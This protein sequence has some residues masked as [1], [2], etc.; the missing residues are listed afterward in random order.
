MRNDYDD[1]DLCEDRGR[2]KQKGGCLGCLGCLIP[3]LILIS[4]LVLLVFGAVGFIWSRAVSP[5]FN[6]ETIAVN[7]D[8]SPS[9]EEESER[10]RSIFLFGVDSRD[11]D[12]L[13]SGALADADLLLTIDQETGEI[14]LTSFYRDT[15]VETTDGSRMKLTEVYSKYGPKEAIQTINK[16]CDLNV[17]EFVTVTWSAVAGLIN[18]LGGIDI[19]ITEAE[20][21]G[22]NTYLNETAENTGISSSPVNEDISETGEIVHLDG[23]QAVSYSRLRK[24]LGDD[25]QRTVRQRTVIAAVFA[26]AK[27]DPKLTAATAYTILPMIATNINILDLFEMAAAIPLYHMGENYGFPH[28]KTDDASYV[29]P[30]TLADNDIWLHTTVY[31][32]SSY[33]VSGTVQAISDYIVSVQ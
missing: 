7:A 31:H 17:T 33:R 11:Q 16:N 9:V 14:T 10:Y 3:L 32:N 18:G 20:A 26:K 5:R 25:Y 19:S 2:K 23:V 8:I 4:A 13:K 21:K 1:R 27:S 24:G 22:I 30:N 15:L 12:P 6:S 29:Y 28:E